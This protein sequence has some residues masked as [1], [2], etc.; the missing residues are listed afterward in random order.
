[1]TISLKPCENL[2]TPAN[3]VVRME[4]RKNKNIVTGVDQYDRNRAGFCVRGKKWNL[5]LE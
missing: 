5:F 1:M 3:H 4:K 2:Q